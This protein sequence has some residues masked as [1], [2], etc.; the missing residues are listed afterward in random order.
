MK[1]IVFILFVI[2]LILPIYAETTVS[3]NTFFSEND[4]TR[5]KTGVIITRMYIKNNASNEN[6]DLKI[7]IPNT[8]YTKNEDFDQYEMVTDEKTFIPFKIT[9]EAEK[10]TFY[11]ILT[12]Y[13]KLTGMQ[14]Y[15]RLRQ[16][17][18]DL[19]LSSYRIESPSNKKPLK[20][21]SYT[22][23]KPKIINYFV[24]KD[25]KFGVLTYSSE[26]YYENNNFILINTCLQPI[27]KF[28]FSV[29]YK[30]EYKI[31]TYFIYDPQLEGFYYYSVNVM[32]IRLNMLMTK[33]DILTLYPSTFSNRLRAGT[34]HFA[35]LMGLDWKNK[36]NPWDEKLLTDGKYK[37]Y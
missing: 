3:V 7:T 37:N 27:S 1:Q 6:T 15:S 34:V 16:Q 33:N 13:S 8:I 19:I 22:E 30:N 20:D 17:V 29:C 5:L 24:Q 14:Y 23:I 31:I 36:I 18:E 2:F 12:S 26:L 11:N 28:V 4:K 25:N 35:G 32:R 21:I 9:S 10:I